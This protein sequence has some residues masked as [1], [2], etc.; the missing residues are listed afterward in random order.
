MSTLHLP[1]H[2]R[3]AQ[4]CALYLQ[5]GVAGESGARQL[6]DL[7]WPAFVQKFQRWGQP[8]CV[9]EEIAS[10]AILNILR[11]AHDM[12]DPPAFEHWAHRVARNAFFT[13]MRATRQER[14]HETQLDEDGWEAVASMAV[15]DAQGNPATML[16]L[17]GQLEKFCR[18]HAERATVLERCVLDGWSIEEVSLALGRTLGA[19]R[20][21]LSQ[22]RKRLQH[23]LL[24]CL[25]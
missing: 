3:L 1:R 6:Y 8:C 4:A 13:C 2:E 5:G 14:N 23:Y 15:D 10:E 25:E 21:Y 11:K 22:C 9:A 16:C 20:Q 18:E 24:P 12:R 17:Q 7:L 19:T